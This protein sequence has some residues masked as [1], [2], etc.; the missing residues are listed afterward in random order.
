MPSFTLNVPNARFDIVKASLLELF[1][2][3]TDKNGDI[4]I[5]QATGLPWTENDWLKNIVT[6]SLIRLVKEGR[7]KLRIR[8]GK[9][10]FINEQSTFDDSFDIT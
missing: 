9:E 6:S 8:E 5:N 4:E 10:N 7:R 3:P 2:I 1:P